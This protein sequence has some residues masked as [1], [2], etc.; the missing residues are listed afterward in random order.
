[1][2]NYLLVDGYNIIHADEGLAQLAQTDSLES[3]RL[4]LCDMLCDFKALSIYRII[5]VFDAHLVSGGVGNVSK[6]RNITVVFTKEAVTADH[7]I[8]R[9][10]YKMADK[11]GDK[12]TV[13]TSDVLEQLIIMGSGAHRISADALLAQMQAA[14]EKMRTRHIQNRPIKQNP[15]INLV[16]EDTARLLEEMR[17]AKRNK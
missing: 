4:K 6:H 2:A 9:A 5:L 15:F 8:E 1:M 13:A 3:A 16:D 12:I 17:H 14:R 7:Y 10:A 11:K